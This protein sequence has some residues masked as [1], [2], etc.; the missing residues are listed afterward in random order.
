M[1]ADEYDGAVVSVAVVQVEGAR[2][3]ITIRLARLRWGTDVLP[4]FL[5]L[6]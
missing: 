2:P 3:R 6:A 1:L 5:L 4:D